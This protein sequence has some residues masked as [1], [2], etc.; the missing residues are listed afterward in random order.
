MLEIRAALACRSAFS[1]GT[2]FTNTILL[3]P[4]PYRFASENKQNGWE[5]GDLPAFKLLFI[6]LYPALCYF[7]EQLMFDVQEA[8]SI[9][10]KCFVK[11]WDHD[12][13]F[14]TFM[15]VQSFMYI[16]VRI[17]CLEQTKHS[18]KIAKKQGKPFFSQVNSEESILAAITQ[19]ET[20]RSIYASMQ[21]LPIKCRR[22]IHIR[23]AERLHHELEAREM[24]TIPDTGKKP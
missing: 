17:A 11:L 13:K 4:I 2:L 19:A 6:E 8:D 20:I 5:P 3:M 23:Y 14:E 10:E 7:A 12:E 18:R 22:L 9:V 15:D 16:S 21:K 1:I 24:G